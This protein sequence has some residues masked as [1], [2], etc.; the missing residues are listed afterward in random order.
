M[1][2]RRLVLLVSLLAMI[3][4]VAT[5]HDKRAEAAD[6][7]PLVQGENFDVKPTGTK[8]VTDTALYAN[9]QALKFNDNTATAAETV[10]FANQGDVVLVAL[11]GQSGGSPTLSVKA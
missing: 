4:F 3:A 11:G 1:L 2:G 9:G 7:A 6:V 5:T 10:N 8:V